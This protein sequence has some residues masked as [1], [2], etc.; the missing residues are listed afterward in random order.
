NIIPN[1]LLIAL[2]RTSLGKIIGKKDNKKLKDLN[3][4][5]TNLRINVK[6]CYEGKAIVGIH[7]EN[8]NSEVS[9]Y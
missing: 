7:N 2:N 4:I 5:K 3:R 9:F 8:K 1:I 6:Q